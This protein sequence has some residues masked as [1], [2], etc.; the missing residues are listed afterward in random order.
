MLSKTNKGSKKLKNLTANSL[1]HYLKVP[2]LG[3]VKLSEPLRFNGK[4]N[5]VT[6]SQNGNK[7]YASFNVSIPLKDYQVQPKTQLGLGIDVGLKSF[8]SLSNGLEIK[9]PKP[10]AKLARKIVKQSR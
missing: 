6:I 10:L 1:A 4:I 7:F 8:V 5:S 2:N 9:A 3:Y